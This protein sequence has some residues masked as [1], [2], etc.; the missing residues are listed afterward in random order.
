[1]HATDAAAGS[2]Q[3]PKLCSSCRACE[4]AFGREAVVKSGDAVFQVNRVHRVYDR[5]AAGRNL[6]CSAAATG[7]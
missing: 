1:M 3:L 5:C 6:A 4:V 7:L 2:S